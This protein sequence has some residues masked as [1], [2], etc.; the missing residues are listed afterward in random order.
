[1]LSLLYKL[2]KKLAATKAANV[3]L[4]LK[5]APVRKLVVGGSGLRHDSDWVSTDIDVLDVTR[6]TNWRSLFKNIRLDFV[7]AEHVWEHLT[8]EQADAANKNIFDFLKPG[9]KFRVAVP[10]G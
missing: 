3:Y 5:Y 8:A 10:D 4:D 1:M 2:R 9:G 7:F 6:E